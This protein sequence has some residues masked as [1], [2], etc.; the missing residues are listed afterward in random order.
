MSRCKERTGDRGKKSWIVSRSIL[1]RRGGTGY[2]CALGYVRVQGKEIRKREEKRDKKGRE[3]GKKGSGESDITIV[4]EYIYWDELCR[5]DMFGKDS[6]R[7]QWYILYRD[8]SWFFGGGDRNGVRGAFCG[9]FI[10][11]KKN[12]WWRERAE[13]T[14]T[15]NFSMMRPCF[16]GYPFQGKRKDVRGRLE[17]KKIYVNIYVMVDSVNLEVIEIKR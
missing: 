17:G 7:R 14:V 5:W 12:W 10:L 1:D 11:W 4:Q 2:V 8:I 6:V 16:T 13:M 15:T 3:E 9:V